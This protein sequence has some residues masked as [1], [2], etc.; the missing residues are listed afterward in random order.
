MLNDNKIQ[1]TLADRVRKFSDIM[2][3]SASTLCFFHCL[4]TPVAMILLPVLGANAL[5]N[6]YFHKFMLFLVLPSTAVAVSLGCRRHKD[7]LVVLLGAA[8]FILLLSGF[9]V[10]NAVAGDYGEILLTIAGGVI[11]VSGHIRNFMLCREESCIHENI[12]ENEHKT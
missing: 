6:E 11:L 4:F 8:G 5:D 1:I 3:I 2:A 7:L 10:G 12:S 9:F